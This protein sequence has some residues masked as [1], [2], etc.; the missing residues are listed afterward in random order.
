MTLHGAEDVYSRTGR[1]QP[2]PDR[3][4]CRRLLDLLFDLC[5][6]LPDRRAGEQG[7]ASGTPMADMIFACALKV[8]TTRSARRFGTDLDETR[9]RRAT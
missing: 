1:V 3:R 6:G 7:P 5:R 2:R 9:T 8:Y 4:K